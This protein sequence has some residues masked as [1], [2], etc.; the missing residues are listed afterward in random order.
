LTGAFLGADA[1]DGANAGDTGGL[2]KKAI[3]ALR[4]AEKIAKKLPVVGRSN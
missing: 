1:K 2:T 3:F 4:A